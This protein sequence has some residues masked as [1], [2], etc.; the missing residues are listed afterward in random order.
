MVENESLVTNPDRFEV[1]MGDEINLLKLHAELLLLQPSLLGVV[2]GDGKVSIDLVGVQGLPGADRIA[3][4]VAVLGHTPFDLGQAK[5]V[6]KN[7]MDGH[8]HEL[9]KEGM[10]YN[11]V[12]ISVTEESQNRYVALTLA[13]G[14]LPYPITIPSMENDGAVPLNNSSDLSTFYGSVFGHCSMLHA[15]LSYWKGEVMKAT[16]QAEIDAAQT[17]YIGT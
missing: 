17:G 4:T 13:S 10:D 6:A 14:G 1:A 8:Y 3:L 5:E 12:T 7:L 2:A 11:G 15:T 9:N 16:T